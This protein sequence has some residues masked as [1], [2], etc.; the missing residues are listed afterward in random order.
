M[1][2]RMLDYR[3][4]RGQG[5]PGSRT[6]AFDCSG[7][8]GYAYAKVHL[9]LPRTADQQYQTARR[10]AKASARPGDLVFWRSGGHV[11]HVGIYAGQGRVWHAPKPGSRVKPA[12]IW[13]W[14]EVRFG[15]IG[16]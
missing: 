12:R 1:R 10:I 4:A 13:S 3:P 14:N 11:Y 6:A 15:R 16:L 9:S 8:T 7:L 2:G 5:V